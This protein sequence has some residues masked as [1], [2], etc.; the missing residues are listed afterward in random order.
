VFKKANFFFPAGESTF[1]VGKSGSGKSTLGNLLAKYYDPACGKISIGG[2]SIQTLDAQWLRQNVML[3]QQQALLFNE[4]VALN[5]AF[6]KAGHATKEEVLRA[7]ETGNLQQTILDLP[8]GLETPIGLNGTS[9]SGGQQ[10]RIGVA[11]ARLRD[12][13][14]VILDEATSALD[15]TSKRKVMGE[16][17][18]WREKKTTIIITHDVS[19]INDNEYVYVLE[20]GKLVQEGYR[21]QLAERDRGAFAS[22]MSTYT[23]R[24][25]STGPEELWKSKPARPTS[26][27]RDDMAGDEGNRWGY[28]SN[29]FG[30][31][32]STTG[33]SSLDMNAPRNSN[34]SQSMQE[35]T[36]TEAPK[37][38]SRLAQVFSPKVFQSPRLRKV[39]SAA[40][41]LLSPRPLPIASFDPFSKSNLMEEIPAV[42]YANSARAG[43]PSP[44]SSKLNSSPAEHQC[45]PL[46]VKQDVNRPNI[47]VSTSK[48][49]RETELASFRDILATV[50]PRLSW[51]YRTYLLLGFFAAFVVAACT[52]AFA[53]VFGRLLGIYHLRGDLVS[54]AEKWALALL[55]IACADGAATF[56]MHYTLECTGQA[57]V[58]S[59]RVEALRRV[60]AQPCPWFYQEE[61]SATRLNECLHRNAEEMRNL[62]GRFAGP[63]L[64]AMWILG[65]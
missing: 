39:G 53:Y 29:I 42:E 57:W 45:S 61:N 50:W 2:H 15:Q 17:R 4:T 1:I 65:I 60:L 16:I 28:G 8:Q 23:S 51:K 54:Q 41:E 21:V 30:I 13:P 26:V 20:N 48:K 24:D 38:T 31:H 34:A 7:S 3:V 59:L 5:I 25:I 62:V 22:L 56:F 12:A 63:V 11:R 35:F 40:M 44:I 14:V 64:T 32:E 9:L 27:P 37:N 10:Q 18:K 52:P 6:G 46:D 33:S 58:N 55:G 36:T 49:V 47:T 43:R 19:Q